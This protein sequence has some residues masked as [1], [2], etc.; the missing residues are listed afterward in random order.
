MGSLPY[1]IRVNVAVPFPARVQGS[2]VVKI[3]KANGIWTISLDYTQL[4]PGVQNVPNPATTYTIAWDAQTGVFYLL[5][6]GNIATNKVIKTILAP[7]PYTADPNDDVIIVKQNIAAPFT[8]NVNWAA[9]AKPLQIVD[10]KG[11][12]S[13]NNITITPSAGQTQLAKVN[14]SYVIDGDGG[15]VILTPLPDGSGAY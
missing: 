10:G 6:L 13:V 1:N 15:S 4:L 2:G 8:V 5:Q 12:A 3:V 9:R 7:G 14:Y 11:D